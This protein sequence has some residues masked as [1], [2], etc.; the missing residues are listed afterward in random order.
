M[1]P[2][3]CIKMSYSFANV[4]LWSFTNINPETFVL[5]SCLRIELLVAGG[6]ILS[7]W[8]LQPIKLGEDKRSL[9]KKKSK[10]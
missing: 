3:G 7:Y 2:K 10:N 6:E 1:F 4:N 5:P 9:I 8:N